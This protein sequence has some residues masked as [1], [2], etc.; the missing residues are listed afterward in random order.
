[1][2]GLGRRYASDVR[3]SRFPLRAVLPPTASTRTHRYWN[4]NG[5]WG[6]QGPSP[7]CV[8]YA[9]CHYLE[10]GPVGQPGK[11]PIVAPDVIYHEAQAVDEWEG[12]YDGTSVRAGAKA[13]QARGFIAAYHWASTIQEITAAL[14]DVGPVVV[15][16]N[17]YEEMFE[18]DE[19][20]LIHIGGA[21]TGGHAFVLD[22]ISLPHQLIRFKNSWG[23]QWNR[24]GFG[25]LAFG[26]MDHLLH[27]DGEAC[28]A[29]EI[30]MNA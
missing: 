16:V 11:A 30:R 26:D 22:G 3:D 10:D 18:G 25:Y 9:W 21:L 23:R 20:G 7:Q 2:P 5:W 6:D 17:W 8:A 13:L 15:G 19:A 29:T 14:L 28:L 1:M 12:E 4:A 24:N 27:E